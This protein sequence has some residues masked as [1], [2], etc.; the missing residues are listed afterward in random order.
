MSNLFSISADGF[1]IETNSLLD[2]YPLEYR[3][4]PTDSENEA[5]IK[6]QAEHAPKLS[7]KN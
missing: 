7:G 5:V 4:E 1:P 2:A 3:N 6:R